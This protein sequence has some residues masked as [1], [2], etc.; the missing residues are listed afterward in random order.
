MDSQREKCPLWTLV[1][2]NCCG[3]RRVEPIT[4]VVSPLRHSFLTI[5]NLTPPNTDRTWK[6][7]RNHSEEDFSQALQR[8]G[9]E[10]GSDQRNGEEN[11]AYP[12]SVPQLGP[13]LL[14]EGT[15]FGIRS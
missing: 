2:A 9:S 3:L 14:G 10:N 1:Q 6:H 5:R 12:P 7:E 15:Q 11:R 13:C 4:F 8:R